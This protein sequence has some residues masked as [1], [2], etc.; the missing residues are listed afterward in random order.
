M[1]SLHGPKK[2]RVLNPSHRKPMGLSTRSAVSLTS[3]VSPKSQNTSAVTLTFIPYSKASNKR[4]DE[5]IRSTALSHAARVSH[6]K[7]AQRKRR[8]RGWKPPTPPKRGQA[9]WFG[10]LGVPNGEHNGIRTE[11]SKL[12]MLGIPEKLI[13]GGAITGAPRALQAIASTLLS[14]LTELFQRSMTDPGLFVSA[15]PIAVVVVFGG[16]A[17]ARSAYQG[18]VD[19]STQ[20]ALVS[21]RKDVNQFGVYLPLNS[22]L[23]ILSLCIAAIVT[24]DQGALNVHARGLFSVVRA[25][26]LRDP[27]ESL[28]WYNFRK[29]M[30]L[31]S[32]QS[33]GKPVFPRSFI[34]QLDRWSVGADVAK[35]GNQLWRAGQETSWKEPIRVS[36]T[37]AIGSGLD[38]AVKAQG[39]F[40]IRRSA[41]I[42]SDATSYPAI[43]WQREG[44]LSESVEECI[45]DV[46]RTTCHMVS[47]QPCLDEDLVVFL[48]AM[49]NRVVA[50]LHGLCS[51]YS[52]LKDHSAEGAQ[53]CE[54]DTCII[55]AIQLHLVIAVDGL[56]ASAV[57][58]LCSRLQSQLQNSFMSSAVSRNRYHEDVSTVRMQCELWLLLTGLYATRIGPVELPECSWFKGHATQRLQTLE[59][60][61]EECIRRICLPFGP[62]AEGMSRSFIQQA[63]DLGRNCRIIPSVD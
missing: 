6:A 55:V 21:I 39:L 62:G 45:L 17:D 30:L 40:P 11:L 35:Y 13:M 32:I 3:S 23:A 33:G 10:G 16:D 4:E 42:W 15:L 51:A 22:R 38:S 36:Q 9:W 28:T 46:R 12:A 27:L 63:V 47:E 57:P 58:K 43:A 41:L 31:Q 29:S 61:A 60:Y 53:T 50:C 1:C 56:L 8:P 48:N 19:Y 18:L 7:S 54:Y 59:L 25:F 5:L 20:R 52:Q 14:A 37:S 44:L 26:D 34:P 24:N 2:D 49:Y